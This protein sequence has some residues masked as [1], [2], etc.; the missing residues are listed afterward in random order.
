V[1]HRP[2]WAPDEI[3][4]EKPSAA[5]VYDYYL[6]GSHNFEADRELARRN[7][8][9]WPDVPHIAR[10]NRAF[11]HRAVAHLVRV[12][13]D[14]FLDLGSGIPTGGNVHEVALDA[15]PR[16]RTVY[17]D[18][19]LVAV[20]HG[21]RLLANVPNA[22]IVNIDLRDTAAVLGDPVVRSLIDF[23]RPVAVLMVSVLHFIPD[24]DDPVG[25]VAAY[26]EATSVG[27]KLVLSHAT[28]EYW[29]ARAERTEALYK[30]S[31]NPMFFRSR[32]EIAELLAE[33]ELLSPGLVDMT[34]W[35]PDPR[36]AGIDPLGGDL[37]RYS[38]LAAVGTRT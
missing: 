6:G 31:S 29:P 11:L 14:Q 15:D 38:G 30:N 16:A 34:L 22:A 37:S 13:V 8:E 5:R 12:G 21:E 1:L 24:A 7:Q 26:H 18:S 33:Y 28:N 10:A 36:F 32:A 20:A 35:R 23:T 17:V 9:I 2:Y 19:D 4:M 3:D 27:S 25:L